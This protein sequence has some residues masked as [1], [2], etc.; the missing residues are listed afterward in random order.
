MN[1]IALSGFLILN[2]LLISFPAESQLRSFNELFPGI[3]ENQKQRIYSE[4]GMI[5]SFLRNET[6]LFVPGKNSGINLWPAVMEK[7]PSQMAE[8]LI[9]V[10]YRNRPLNKLDIYNVL[11]KV[12]GLSNYTINSRSRGTIALFSES[13]RIDT[14]NRNSPI[15]DPPPALILPSAETIYGRYKDPYF[16]NTYLRGD[17]SVNQY[18]VI[19]RLTNTNTI[20]YFI[21]PV[22]GAEKL[23]LVFYA[24]PVAEGL[25][26]YGLAGLDIPMF[27]ASNIDL[28]DHINMR[29]RIVMNWLTDNI[30][31]IY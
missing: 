27:I 17:F 30:K 8:A 6:S 5:H 22:M 20:W 28:S 4:E 19:Y 14:P 15:P 29:V 2:I 26:V 1:K 23:A 13:T 24:E 12:R 7:I 16:G 25:L 3:T 18:G 31:E 9:V 21:F 10:P 11:G